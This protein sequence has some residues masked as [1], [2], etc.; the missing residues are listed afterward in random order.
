M[1]A[2]V[3][4][5]G[6]AGRPAVSIRDASKLYAS[7]GGELNWAMTGVNLDIGEGE[8]VCAI[9]PSGCG[10]TT[11]LNTIAGFIQPTTGSV[12]AGGQ[13]VT[14]PGA[15]RGVVFQEYALFPWLTARRNIEF[16]L[17]M[18]GLD[19]PA[20][21]AR[22]E[23]LLALT[24]LSHAAGRYPFELSGGMR[25]RIAVARALAT[26][27]RVLLMD[28]P[29]AAID[30]LTRTS[31]QRELLRIWQELRLSV[32][33]ITHNIEEAVF[34]AQRV[35]VMSAHPGRIREIVDIDLPYPRNRADPA[36]GALYERISAAFAQNEE[37]T[38]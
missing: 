12:V 13:P 25:Q 22:A 21:R 1:N 2:S 29:F 34:L 3:K 19:A 27:P 9:G 24:G 17:K 6:A 26:Q 37:A 38:A 31:L 33:F 7:S 28:E 36:F 4:E 15:D 18:Q 16:G 35:V 10:K 20:R 8:F 30:A 14:G 32:F 23:E 11:L 5:T